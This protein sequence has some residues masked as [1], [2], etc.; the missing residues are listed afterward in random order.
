MVFIK[1]AALNIPEIP[2]KISNVDFSY[3]N[4]GYAS[5]ATEGVFEN[6]HS[7]SYRNDI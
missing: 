2:Y 1:G 5:K 6:S 3:W 4:A 7:F